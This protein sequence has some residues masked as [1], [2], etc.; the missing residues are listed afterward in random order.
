M[1]FIKFSTW[2]NVFLA[3]SLVYW[4]SVVV[5]YTYFCSFTG[6]EYDSNSNKLSPVDS[7]NP[8]QHLRRT[9]GE[10]EGWE[11]NKTISH[12]LLLDTGFVT[13]SSVLCFSM[14]VL[15]TLFHGW[16]YLNIHCVYT[17]IGRKIC[18]ILNLNVLKKTLYTHN[19]FL[20]LWAV[21]HK[22]CQ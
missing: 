17:T 4:I 6:N 10:S 22:M 13:A 21:H 16:I 8:A 11:F 9:N 7:L 18:T 5:H 19:I 1:N 15:P 12:S 3:F 20:S 14:A 2:Y